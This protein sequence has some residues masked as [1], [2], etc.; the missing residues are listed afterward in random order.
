VSSILYE[1]DYGCRPWN[2]PTGSLAYLE[3]AIVF[4]VLQIRQVFCILATCFGLHHLVPRTLASIECRIW[5]TPFFLIL[6]VKVRYGHCALTASN[7]TFIS[8]YRPAHPPPCCFL[9]AYMYIHA[10]FASI[11]NCAY[12]EFKPFVFG[13]FPGPN[14]IQA[15]KG[16]LHINDSADKETPQPSKDK[17][18]VPH[19]LVA[20][21]G[22]SCV[23]ICTYLPALPNPFYCL[24]NEIS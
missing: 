4:W 15:W 1:E 8:R 21:R 13:R 10:A 17:D 2:N 16:Q 6:R 11:L 14:I 7:V 20:L 24:F 23:T 3:P 22:N 19:F 18:I 9:C 12:P 5:T